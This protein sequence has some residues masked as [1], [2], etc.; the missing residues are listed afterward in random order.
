MPPW[1]R[2]VMAQCESLALDS[3]ADREK[4]WSVIRASWP[5]L[6]IQDAVLESQR[7]RTSVTAA[8][9]SALETA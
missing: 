5:M 2:A 1:F 7:E 6:E 3:E 4:L 9:L 8:V